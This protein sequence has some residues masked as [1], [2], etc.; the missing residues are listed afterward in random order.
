MK[1]TDKHFRYIMECPWCEKSRTKKL[2]SNDY[3]AEII[4]CLECGFIYSNKILNK[5]GLELY[6]TNY[7]SLVQ[8]KD[9]DLVKNRNKMYNLEFEYIN[10]IMDCADKSVLD[11]GCGNGKFLDCFSNA[12]ARCY[13]IEYGNEAAEETAKK[14]KVWLGEFPELD[15]NL[16]F[17]LIIFRGTLQYCI[18]P[19]RY[20]QKAM[21]LLNSGGYIYITSTPNAES[22][23]F[24]LFRDNFVLPVS[25]TDYYAF[26]ESVLTN[27]IKE[28]GGKLFCQYHFYEET[29]YANKTNDII[30]VAKAIE[31]AQE[32]KKVYFKSPP[33][34]DNMLTLVYQKK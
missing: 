32:N 11:I 30:K 6:W 26:K 14:Y 15:I 18:Q 21:E 7:L 22:I 27:Y 33:F 4:E 19:K 16:K 20:L 29:P 17:D 24:N 1:F 28:L 3:D 8:N 10:N 13:G 2:Y 5:T 25:V 23:C 9:D 34:Y 31:L 12:K